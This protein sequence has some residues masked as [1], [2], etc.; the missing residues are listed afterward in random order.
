MGPVELETP[1]F[2]VLLLMLRIIFM[3]QVLLG[4]VYQMVVDVFYVNMIAVQIYYGLKNITQQ[5]HQ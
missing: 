3:Q 4:M 1:D 5:R 2:I